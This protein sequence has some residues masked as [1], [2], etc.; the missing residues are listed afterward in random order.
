MRIFTVDLL[1]ILPILMSSFETYSSD[2]GL[3]DFA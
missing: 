3:Y 2:R 1:R